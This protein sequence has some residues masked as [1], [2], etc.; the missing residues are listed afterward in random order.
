MLSIFRLKSAS[1]TGNYFEKD[2]YYSKDADGARKD[3]VWF[4]RGAKDLGLSGTVD[5]NRFKELLSG[6]IDNQTVLG[7]KNT[8]KIS[9]APGWD[10]T[11][12]AP[13]SASVQYEIGNDERVKQAHLN[14]VK[15]AMNYVENN[16]LF[17]RQ[18]INGHV[19]YVPTSKSVSAIFTHHTSRELDPQLH[20]HV[21]LM[22]ATK[23]SAGDWRSVE[24]RPIYQSKM[25]VG[26]I[27]RSLLAKSITEMGYQIE[28]THTDGRFDIVGVPRSV[29]DEFS[30]RRL[31]MV[32]ELANSYNPDA[33][34]AERV[35]LMTRKYK[36]GEN[37]EKLK[38][39][40]ADR[41]EKHDFDSHA[42]VEKTDVSFAPVLIDPE[43]AADDGVLYA[44]AK[45]S[46]REAVFTR[47]NILVDALKHSLGK[48]DVAD[49]IRSIDRNP[50]KKLI[51]ALLKG[52]PAFTTKQAIFY[53][54]ANIALVLEGNNSL[55]PI[56]SL[57][58]IDKTV[59]GLSL[60]L[61]QRE[62]IDHILLSKH[63][64]MGVQGFA[65]TGKTFM[66]AQ[67]NDIASSNK[68]NVLG[69]AP[70][71]AV[72]DILQKDTG[73]QSE[74]LAL[75]L[76]KNKAIVETKNKDNADFSSQLWVVDEASLVSNRD[77]Y[78]LLR[79]SK[80]TGAR[81]VLTGDDTQLGSIEAGKPFSYLQRS[82]LKMA[83][84][85][86]II[87]QK[88]PH[89]LAAVYDVIGGKM[90]KVFSRISNDVIEIED[91]DKRLEAI[92]NAYLSSTERDDLLVLSPANDDRSAISNLIRRGLKREG[93]LSGEGVNRQILVNHQWE[94]AVKK[95][96]KYYRPGMVIVLNKAL[97]K[98]GNFKGEH[99]II[100]S[101]RANDGLLVL[102]GEEGRIINFDTERHGGSRGL[103]DVHFS[104]TREINKG[105]LLLWKKNDKSL[106]L[107]NGDKLK[108]T[109]V[110]KGKTVV[111]RPNGSTL[112]LDDKKQ[113][114]QHFD[115]HYVSTVYRSQ[116]MTSESVLLHGEDYRKQLTTQKSFYV[117]LSRA[118]YDFKLFV[119]NKT[120]YIDTLKHN[121]GHKTSAL[122]SQVKQPPVKPEKQLYNEKT[123][124]K[125][126]TRSRV[127]SR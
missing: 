30:T 69:F 124:T 28:Q 24:S 58:Q 63:R 40:W 96:T 84:M 125:Q 78:H 49:I 56:A 50:D 20:S 60:K 42:L 100:E 4:G 29:L 18:L 88:T 53:E 27:Y 105:D 26:L 80:L 55:Q 47:E 86:D 97:D 107:I 66:L 92:S 82:S 14:A 33:K 15:S 12:S 109:S 65:G 110:K 61:G 43:Q 117:G 74:T 46:E 83:K 54:K 120:K 35:A 75:H 90:K 101:V 13:K 6:K 25:L 111:E 122:E 22:N 34:A 37:K 114:H 52:E 81:V 85:D 127:K 102:R 16:K 10:M 104:D 59:R 48:A 112:S 123:N 76:A 119:N 2:D 67:V 31:Q 17:T 8:D 5:P 64:V 79:L 93:S 36:T 68:L 1:Q 95:V 77:M 62:A 115:Y 19:E 51:P 91:K 87:R 116:G 9:H 39:D 72:R 103:V 57:S 113:G 70:S 99:F 3:S 7:K 73:I 121:I 11:F 38:Q 98:F 106:G 108:V 71:T 118:K 94:N 89:L 44:V 126:N 41:S 21:V 32:K 45:L 23:N